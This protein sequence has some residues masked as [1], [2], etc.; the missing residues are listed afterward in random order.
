MQLGTIS[1][2]L[3]RIEL[4]VMGPCIDVQNCF[5]KIDLYSLR[6]MIYEI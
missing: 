4:V 3:I 5:K 2:E 1:L 6:N